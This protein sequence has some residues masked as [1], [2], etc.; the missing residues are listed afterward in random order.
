M[1]Y[2]SPEVRTG[3]VVG[4]GTVVLLAAD[5]RTVRANLEGVQTIRAGASQVLSGLAPGQVYNAWI[6][7]RVTSSTGEFF[8]RGLIVE[9]VS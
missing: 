2:L 8:Y 7:H 5:S 9:P 1:A 3:P 4:S 6:L